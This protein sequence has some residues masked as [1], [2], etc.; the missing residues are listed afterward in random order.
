MTWASIGQ[1]V[2]RQLHPPALLFLFQLVVLDG[3]VDEDL[4]RE[5]LDLVT[6]PGWA[7]KSPQEPATPATTAA[8]LSHDQPRS[9][10]G[11]TP[12]REGPPPSKWERGLTD[13]DEE[14]EEEGEGRGAGPGSWGLT[15]EAMEWLCRHGEH[16]AI[17]E[18]C[19]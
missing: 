11:G 16:P 10:T 9:G 2:P 19:A 6:E 14:E 12:V 3:L 17:V 1:I 4:C 18:V 15:E 8:A 13:V 5:L 7:T